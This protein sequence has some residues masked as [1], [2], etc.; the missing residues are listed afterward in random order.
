LQ[1]QATAKELAGWARVLDRRRALY[2]QAR[3]ELAAANLR[4]V[5]SIAKGYRGR[6]LPFTD[7]IQEGNSGL[8]RAVDKFD[9]RLGFKFGTYATW[10]IRQGIT[11]ALYDT[12]RMVR[13]PSHRAGL[14]REVEQAQGDL[15]LKL[16]REPTPEEIARELK[17]TAAEVQA[18]L[19]SGRQPLSIDNS[20]GEE[21]EDS[22]HSILPDREAAS[23]AEEADRQF[24]KERVAETLRCLATRDREIIELRYACA[25]ESHAPSKRSRR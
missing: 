12:S 20:Y 21:A 18:T 9:Y 24:L 25:T 23:P 19:A 2:Q 4:L 8:M 1:P 15:L 3:Q 17:T 13:V 22:F 11:R 16:H 14:L 10:W 5:I 7:L 6:G